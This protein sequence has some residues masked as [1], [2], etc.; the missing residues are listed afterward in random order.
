M[1]FIEYRDISIDFI[2]FLMIFIEFHN[3]S[4]DFLGFLMI[5]IDFHDF[6][7][8]GHPGGRRPEF[9]YPGLGY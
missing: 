4:I 1:L 9:R 5:F 8:L 6:S 7:L 3:I 2:G